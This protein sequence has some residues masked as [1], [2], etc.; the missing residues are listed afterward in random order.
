M[1]EH[2]I[3][4]NTEY[5]TIEVPAALYRTRLP[6]I[7]RD[8]YRVLGHILIQPP[9]NGLS[10]VHLSPYGW[11]FSQ[12]E[13]ILLGLSQYLFEIQDISSLHVHGLE[14]NLGFVIDNYITPASI[15][16]AT[17]THPI[18]KCAIVVLEDQHRHILIGKRPEGKFMPGVWEFP[19]GKFEPY[20]DEEAAAKRELIEELG[21]HIQNY[22]PICQIDYAF[23]HFT[24]KGYISR[25]TKWE[26]IPRAYIHSELRWV[27][28][29][30]LV[31][32][33][34]PL[35]NLLFLPDLYKNSTH[36]DRT[37]PLT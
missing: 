7:S 9:I 14:A 18:V 23:K 26:G 28:I 29:K 35:S 8:P 13:E 21:I 17:K 37:R 19:G 2:L 3:T 36:Y 6:V 16:L 11:T 31:Q 12:Q 5:L 24:L 4:L 30:D 22:Q 27:P 25:V 10:Q 15:R 1:D 33:P 20:E 34:M 32:T